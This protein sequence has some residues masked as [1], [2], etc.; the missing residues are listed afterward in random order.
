LSSDW[1]LQLRVRGLLLFDDNG[2]RMFEVTDDDFTALAGM[3]DGF[4]IKFSLS[5]FSDI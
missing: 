4:F 1:L 5:S 3:R 2:A